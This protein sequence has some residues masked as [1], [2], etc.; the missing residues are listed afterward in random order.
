M[1]FSFHLFF[2]IIAIIAVAT[3]VA[4]VGFAEIMQQKFSAT[5]SG[6]GIRCRFFQQL[7]AYILLVHGF[8]FHE[9]LEF[10]QIVI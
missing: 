8:A 7:A 5:Y 9:L 1:F 6:L 2:R 3:V 4:P 10:F